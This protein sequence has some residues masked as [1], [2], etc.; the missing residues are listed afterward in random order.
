M[1]RPVLISQLHLYIINAVRLIRLELGLSQR[2]VSKYLNSE[3]DNNILGSI[4]SN[5]R[6]E[7]YTDEHLNKLAN[8]FSEILP[9]KDY[10]IY[11]FYPPQP[12]I[13]TLVEKV[14]VDIPQN[15]GPTGAITMLLEDKDP[16]FNEWHTVKE[17]TKYCNEVLIRD[18]KTTDFTSVVARA[19]IVG[20]LLRYDENEPRYKKA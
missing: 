7:K 16:F 8:K 17:V 20:K 6:N 1:E 15:I 5:Y 19:E 14:V 9:N 2:D 18:W 10:S 13:E 11:D 4:E 3:T 12:I